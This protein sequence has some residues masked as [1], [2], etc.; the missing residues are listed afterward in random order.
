V[1]PARG[2]EVGRPDPMK[3]YAEQLGSA[4]ASGAP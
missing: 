4:G 2:H 1:A 3:T